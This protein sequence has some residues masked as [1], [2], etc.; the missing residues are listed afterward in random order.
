MPLRY[1]AAMRKAALVLVLAAACGNGTKTG[2]KDAADQ[3]IIDGPPTID[4]PALIGCTPVNGTNVKLRQIGRVSGGA[5]LAT[6]PPN[7]GRLFVVEQ[8]GR[9]RIFENE[10]LK[11][12]PFLDVTNVAGFAAGGEQGLL[13]LAFHP[14][15]ANNRLFYVFYTLGNANVVAKYTQS[16]TDPNV[17]DPAS[18]EVLLSI[19]D[20]ASNH[21]G[22]MMEFGADG[23]LYIGTGDGG[24][25]GD[26]NRNGQN[27]NALLGKMLRID[28][29]NPGGGKPYGIPADN[30][31]ATAGGAPEVFMLGLRNPWRWSFDRATG[32]MWIADV[33]QGLIEELTVVKAGEQ[34][35][36][37]LGWS[38][39]EG[40]ACYATNYTPCV[41]SEN[42]SNGFTGPQVTRTHG[43]NW[44][45]IIGGQVYRG[46]CFPDLVGA[47]FMT[48]NT[49]HPLVKAT[50]AGG[51]V[52]TTDMPPP[53]GGWPTSPASIH[54]DARGELFLTN[55]AGFVYQI[56]AGP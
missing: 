39:Y 34:A 24:G 36:K 45:A 11:T 46:Q 42:N 32:D 38:K 20:F 53:T 27:P 25:G 8:G 55:T 2:K 6:S 23:Y 40:N 33:G 29:N 14:N 19:P 9:I 28:V 21:N 47:Y 7:D 41:D 56:E 16:A 26:P 51:T 13:G 35:G 10:M 22:G 37:N 52:T 54:A 44:L 12:T 18:A 50:F 3:P 31:F 43:Q 30:P 49:A 5:M 48:D 17:A 1:Y 15:Y 4:A